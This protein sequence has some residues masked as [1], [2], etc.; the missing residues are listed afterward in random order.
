MWTIS[1]VSASNTTTAPQSKL[2]AGTR[3]APDAT[4]SDHARRALQ[5]VLPAL[6]AGRA[7][8]L[9]ERRH[10]NPQGSGLAPC[11]WC[12]ARVDDDTGNP[13][14]CSLPGDGR[15]LAGLEAATVIVGPGK[16]GPALAPAP[17]GSH[18]DQFHAK[19]PGR[20]FDTRIGRREEFTSLAS[21]LDHPGRSPIRLWTTAIATHP[22]AVYLQGVA[23]GPLLTKK[24][25]E[26]SS[27]P[28][29]GPIKK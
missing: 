3:K 1:F 8:P 25:C 13:R 28:P 17:I 29:A 24:T 10:G 9:A 20:L 23:E 4:S 21:L 6:R 19:A 14:R 15:G 22:P 27:K 18:L 12:A 26:C 16:E 5:R 2:P 11:L 7:S